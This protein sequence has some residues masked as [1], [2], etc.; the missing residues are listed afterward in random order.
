ML[1]FYK[2]LDER[3]KSCFHDDKFGNLLNLDFYIFIV[4]SD[5]IDE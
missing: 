5:N 4:F 3:R 1:A 2:K